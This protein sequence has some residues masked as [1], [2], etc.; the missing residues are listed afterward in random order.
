MKARHTI[1]SLLLSSLL[2]QSFLWAGGSCRAPENAVIDS[3]VRCVESGGINIGAGSEDGIKVA[4]MES[5]QVQS[6]CGPDGRLTR[7][8]AFTTWFNKL[9]QFEGECL[10]SGGSFSFHDPKF[11]EPQNESFCL[12]AQPEV[13]SNMF[14]EPLCNY[15]SVCPAITVTCEYACRGRDGKGAGDANMSATLRISSRIAN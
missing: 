7:L 13:G 1:F 6:Q 9:K 5:K 14:E 3:E 4:C 15:R 8:R 2:P 10:S 12:Q 11:T